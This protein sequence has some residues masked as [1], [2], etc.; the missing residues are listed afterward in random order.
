LTF[1]LE[2][3]DPREQLACRETSTGYGAKLDNVGPPFSPYV[4]LNRVRSF[5][6]DQAA[7]VHDVY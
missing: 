2:I 1:A 4:F 7:G 3:G 5:K 6:Q